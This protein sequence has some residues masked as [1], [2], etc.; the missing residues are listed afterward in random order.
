MKQ[1][2][3]LNAMAALIALTLAFSYW[4]AVRPGEET[5]VVKMRLKPGAEPVLPGSPFAVEDIEAVTIPVVAGGPEG[6]MGEAD[7]AWAMD[8]SETVKQALAGRHYVQAVQP[9]AFLEPR[10]FYG[11]RD[12]DL[13]PRI[14]PGH[15]A[16][17]FQFQRDNTVT[18]FIAPGALVDVVGVIEHADDTLEAVTFLTAAEIMAVGPI[19]SA[20]EYREI[21]D[22]DF[23]TIT[24]QATPEEVR[25]FLVLQEQAGAP[26]SL[27][28]RA[29]DAATPEAP[30]ETTSEGQ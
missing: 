19:T 29:P 9:G 25:R 17:S 22:P 5:V 2:F 24:V 8:D 3:L 23:D 21:D 12:L 11:G 6:S 13:T 26:P 20:A 15:Q 28:L 14:R 27:I 1:D 4:Q 16:F 18:G 30:D 10:H 7:F